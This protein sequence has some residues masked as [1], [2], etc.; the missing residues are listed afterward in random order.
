MKKTIFPEPAGVACLENPA[1]TC[2]PSAFRAMLDRE[3]ARVDRIG[4]V[5]TLVIWDVRAGASEPA[6][7]RLVTQR[8]VDG[9][10]SI[11]VVGWLETGEL[12]VLLPSTEAQGAEIFARNVIETIGDSHPLPGFSML[13]Y[14][15]NWAWKS[16]G[17]P[18]DGG[19]N[20]PAS[21]LFQKKAP[22]WKRTID[23]AGSLTGFL[24]L[25]PLF[26]LIAVYIKLVSRGKVLFKQDR[27]GRGGRTFTFLKFRTMHENCD[28][29]AH[30]AHLTTLIKKA[31][32]MKK[33]DESRDPRIIPGGNL[34]RKSSLDELPQLL[35]VL[36]GEMSLVGPR[37]CIPYE[38]KEYLQWHTN[39]FDTPPGMTGLWQVS[40]K[41]RLS[42]E[43]MIRLDIAYGKRMSF[44]FDVGILFR[45]IPTVIG[46]FLEALKRKSQR[47]AAPNKASS[48]SA[49]GGPG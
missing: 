23:I 35:N 44:L 7:R 18:V 43:E 27:V 46:L 42:F 14:P 12:S 11:D 49:S 45:T 20:D 21:G 29:T 26:L 10:R 39:R 40:G 47:E 15:G 9:M 33:L 1:A 32:P 41:N 36:R 19:E 4:G 31:A 2:S 22:F 13:S 8:I 30:R 17:N 5:F 6:Y 37:P 16:D 34:L 48:L 3:R 24:L 38:A 25:S 28:D